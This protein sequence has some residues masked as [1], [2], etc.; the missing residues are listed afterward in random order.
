MKQLIS[1]KDLQSFKEQLLQIDNSQNISTELEIQF[2]YNQNNFNLDTIKE[3]INELKGTIYKKIRIKYAIEKF[4]TINNEEC[5]ELAEINNYIKQTTNKELLL[6]DDNFEYYEFSKV[7]NANRM[8]NPLIDKIKKSQYSTFEKFMLVYEFATKFCYKEVDENE[9]KSISRHW[10]SVLNTDKIVCVGYASLM[11]ELCDRIFNEN[12]LKI[13]CQ[14]LTTI[15]LNTKEQGLHANNAIYIKDEKY[16]I[17][18]L[19]YLDA[20]W[21]SSKAGK[22]NQA[23]SFCCIP[24]EDITKFKYEYLDLNESLALPYL[25]ELDDYKTYAN[26]QTYKTYTKG[27][28]YAQYYQEELYFYK[29]KFNVQVNIDKNISTNANKRFIENIIK[30]IKE[31][32]PEILNS[33]TDIDLPLYFDEKLEHLKIKDVHDNIMNLRLSNFNDIFP[34]LEKCFDK[35]KSNQDFIKNLIKKENIQKATIDEFLE[36]FLNTSFIE[37]RLNFIDNESFL[38]I[39]PY[40]EEYI[41]NMTP[42][43]E[44]TIPIE[45]FINGFKVIGIERGLEKN[46]LKEFVKECLVSSIKRTHDIFDTKKCKH[47]LATTKIE[48]IE[49]RV[50]KIR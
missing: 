13:F 48:D 12:E 43:F 7:I 16:G 18:G 28:L 29:N 35:I 26:E 27:L 42:L 9:K 33:I 3:I 6:S 30:S 47:C 49:K 19:F 44:T 37:D 34:C 23:Y 25:H 50:T 14:S 17:D 24:F 36:N 38:H 1:F 8:I 11:K 21:D 10:V 4:Q 2:F 46:E 15:D 40:I 41:K 31:K 45:A 22:T 20:C 5:S 39:Q 32:K